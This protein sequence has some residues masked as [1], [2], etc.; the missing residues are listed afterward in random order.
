MRVIQSK[1]SINK[2]YFFWKDAFFSDATIESTVV[3]GDGGSFSSFE[4]GGCRK[5]AVPGNT[6]WIIPVF[7]AIDDGDVLEIAKKVVELEASD[8]CVGLLH[9]SAEG[10][11]SRSGRP[12]D[13]NE[14]RRHSGGI[15][16]CRLVVYLNSMQQITLYTKDYC[17]YCKRAKARL[18]AE[19]LAYE[20]IDITEDET[21][22]EELKLRSGLLT[23]PQIFV[24]DVLIG[25]SDDLEAKIEEVKKLA[26][27]G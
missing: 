20:E 5:Q 4:D 14:N 7:L 2:D 15:I 16:S 25:G 12:G 21:A 8:V 9:S 27:S 3:M 17:P 24:G 23:V 13:T 26:S 6:G 22:F 1:K 10:G 11:F 18:E 19:G